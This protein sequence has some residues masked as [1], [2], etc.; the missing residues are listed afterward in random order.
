[1]RENNARKKVRVNHDGTSFSLLIS[2]DVLKLNND[3]FDQFTKKM[4]FENLQMSQPENYEGIYFKT[5]DEY[6]KYMKSK[7]TTKVDPLNLDQIYSKL[8]PEFPRYK[9]DTGSKLIKT[10]RVTSD[11]YKGFEK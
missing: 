5:H 10:L 11:E 9:R 1:M 4:I 8:N 7:Y 6:V 2:I 3:K